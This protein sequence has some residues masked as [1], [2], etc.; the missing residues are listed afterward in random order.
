VYSLDNRHALAF[1]YWARPGIRTFAA[2]DPDAG[3]GTEP[4]DDEEDES[5]DDDDP[6]EDKSEDDLRA[7]L[8]AVRA[9]L[10]GVNG[11]SAKR[12][13]KVRSLEAELAK[14]DTPAPK[15]KAADGDGEPVDLDAVREAARREAAAEAAKTRKADKAELALARSGVDDDKLAKAVRL[16]DLDEIDLN[17]DGTLDGM[18]EQIAGLKETWPEMFAPKRRSRTSVAGE[19]DRD[20]ENERKNAKLK[21]ASEKQAA[22]LLG[23]ASS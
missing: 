15:A 2:P 19:A 10:K 23:R 14:R 4:D 1:P 21:S 13:A 5:D 7:E 16:L 11:Q 8:K 18:D 22:G 6:D 20:G 12:R 3:G 17:D 9:Q